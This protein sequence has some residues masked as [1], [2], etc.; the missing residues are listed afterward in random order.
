MYSSLSLSLMIFRTEKDLYRAW[1]VMLYFYLL[2]IAEPKIDSSP[3]CKTLPL[4]LLISEILLFILM[5]MDFCYFVIHVFK[6]FINNLVELCNAYKL[7][8]TNMFAWSRRDI[9]FVVEHPIDS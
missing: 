2:T 4:E 6:F 7:S 5:R 9:I 1:E 3:N 8:R